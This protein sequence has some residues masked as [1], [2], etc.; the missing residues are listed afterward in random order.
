VSLLDD[1]RELSAQALTFMVRLEAVT[2]VK[3][4]GAGSCRGKVSFSQPPWNACAAETLLVFHAQVRLL[5]QRLRAELC[6]PCRPRGGSDENTAKAVAAISRLC[7]ST[8]ESSV[9]DVLKSLRSW[10]RSASIVLQDTEAP[11]RL[12]RVPGLPEPVCPFCRNHTLR[13]LPL[14]GIIRCIGDCT[15]DQGRRPVAHLE[16]SPVTHDW[17]PVWQ[18]G[19]AGVPAAA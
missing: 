13:L 15:D 10:C 16:F 18:D 9:Q 14:E 1:L 11:R 3:L 4:R 6:L 19:I 17:V 2:A 8:C 5:E 12:P 7:T